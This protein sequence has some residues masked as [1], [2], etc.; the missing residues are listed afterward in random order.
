[1]KKRILSHKS[2]RMTHGT[3]VMSKGFVNRW[4]PIAHHFWPQ[5]GLLRHW[6]ALF[7]ARDFGNCKKG[8]P[9][10]PKNQFQLFNGCFNWM[11]ATP[12]LENGWKSPNIHWKLVVESSRK[13][14]SHTLWG[15]V[16]RYLFNPQ[17]KITKAEL[18]KDYHLPVI[19]TILG[20]LI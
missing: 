13:C 7:Q 11:I 9:G 12:L 16:F 17:P 10:T 19:L 6:F 4:L 5:V 18:W 20:F 8:L 15:S 14:S 3:H 1:M 2:I